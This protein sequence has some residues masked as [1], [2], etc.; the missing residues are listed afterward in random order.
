M[1]RDLGTR[2]GYET[3]IVWS[4]GL[5]IIWLSY[6]GFKFD[7]ESSTGSLQKVVRMGGCIQ[8]L[9]SRQNDTFQEEVNL[10]VDSLSVPGPSNF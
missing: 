5:W 1:V 9:H 2:V 6:S 10:R 3:I 8:T 4:F 7:P